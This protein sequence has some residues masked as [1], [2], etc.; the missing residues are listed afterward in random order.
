V[1]VDAT[2]TKSIADTKSAAQDIERAGYDGLWVG[3]TKS[4]PFLQLLHAAD[5]T[6]R[7][8]VGTAIA[9]AFARTPMTIASA[10][11]DMAQ[12]S[13]GR[14][15]LGLGSQVKTH[16]ER[17]FS[18]PWS[19]PAA[20]M[21]EF[22]LALRSIWSNWQDGAPLDFR[23][24]YYTHTLM[25]PFFSPDPHQWGPPPVFIAGVGERMTDVAGEV[26]DGFFFHPFTTDRYMREVTL[27]ALHAG[28]SRSGHDGLEGFTVAGP[29]F[30]CTGRDEAELATAI[31]GTKDQIAFYASTPAYRGVLELHGWGDLQ[32]EL[33]R[34]S[35]AGRW[36]EMGDVID[37]ELLHAFA[38][39]GEPAIVGKGL[40]TRWGPVATRI[41]LY[42]TYK[43]HPALWS[44][45]ID[46]I[47]GPVDT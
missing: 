5:A 39:V 33:T 40:A 15:V 16:I 24:D 1:L 41:T 27:P 31:K 12:Y 2:L 45:V 32:P 10:A 9:I 43:S 8:T 47:R 35:K 4:E 23:G 3:E 29:A 30:T 44:T 17:R 46:S 38:I 18:M 19:H 37:D 22:V 20:R 7:I 42:A 11:Y 13:R 14:F 28:R 26:G 6:E 34:L 36:S 21:R 25:T